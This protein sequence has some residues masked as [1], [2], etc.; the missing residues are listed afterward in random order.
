MSRCGDLRDE[1]SYGR[2]MRTHWRLDWTP[3]LPITYPKLEGALWNST[4]LYKDHVTLLALSTSSYCRQLILLLFLLLPHF[5][6][7][8]LKCKLMHTASLFNMQ[9][10]TNS[11]LEYPVFKYEL[12]KRVYWHLFIVIFHFCRFQIWNLINQL[13]YKVSCQIPITIV[14]Y[15]SSAILWKYATGQLSHVKYCHMPSIKYAAGWA[16]KSSIH[17]LEP[18]Q[19]QKVTHIGYKQ[20]NI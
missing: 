7:R 11:D 10:A 12:L 16:N 20:M 8:F 1:C 14:C 18:L 17:W 15:L 19:I 13:A 9:L 4:T 5:M 3:A 2:P 6:Q